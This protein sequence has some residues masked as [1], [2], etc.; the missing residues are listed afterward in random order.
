MRLPRTRTQVFAILFLEFTTLGLITS[1]SIPEDVEVTGTWAVTIETPQ[2]TGTPTLILKQ[3]GEKITGT[4]KGRM[5][6]SKVEGT[7]KGNEIKLQFT[8]K[9]QDQEVAITYA[10]R[11]EKES[12]KGTA[13]FGEFGSGTWTAKRKQD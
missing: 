11:A 4:Y 3:E 6:E 5:G 12:M 7:L 2:G 9:F 8:L 10:G 13:Q 1:W